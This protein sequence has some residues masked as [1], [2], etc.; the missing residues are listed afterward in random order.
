MGDLRGGV[1]VW[2]LCSHCL[3]DRDFWDCARGV[4]RADILGCLCVPVLPS[5]SDSLCFGTLLWH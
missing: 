3:E 2:I 4:S 5:L 1:G